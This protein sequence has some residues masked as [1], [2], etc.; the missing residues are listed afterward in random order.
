MENF[1]KKLNLPIPSKLDVIFVITII[2]LSVICW[3]QH[4][5]ISD[6]EEIIKS[7][8][9]E[10]IVQQKTISELDKSYKESSEKILS[11]NSRI[12][13]TEKQ[14]QENL[15]KILSEIGNCKLDENP[16]EF[17]IKVRKDFQEI[18]NNLAYST[19]KRR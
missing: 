6:K 2:I 14:Y 19:K 7:K 8:N 13:T 12:N 9:T 5:I 1:L 4:N 17:E 3:K 11:M 15:N 10:I 16:T 18:L